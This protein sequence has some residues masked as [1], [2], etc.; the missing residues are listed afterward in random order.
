MQQNEARR[1]APVRIDIEELG[2]SYGNFAALEKV[3]LT[4]KPGELLALLGPS[5][6][7]KTTL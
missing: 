1:H 5:G 7:G 4:V 6:S 2:K 3:S